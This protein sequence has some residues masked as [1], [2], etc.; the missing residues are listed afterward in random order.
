MRKIKFIERTAIALIIGLH[1]PAYLLLFDK[2]VFGLNKTSI[3]Y[4]I[5]CGIVVYA[6]MTFYLYRKYKKMGL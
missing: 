2:T 4:I 1:V 3:V 6:I 5:V